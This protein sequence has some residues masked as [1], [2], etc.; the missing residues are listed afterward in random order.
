MKKVFIAGFLSALVA[1]FA[2]CATNANTSATGSNAN[3]TN[4]NA[5]PAPIA[6]QPKVDSPPL[7]AEVP[8]FTDARE[9]LE[10]G[11]RYFENNQDDKAINAFE[12]AVKLDPDSG[13]AHFHLGVAYQLNESNQT[14]EETPAPSPSKSSKSKKAPAKLPE[15]PS[16]KE[17]RA[18]IKAYEAYLKKNPKDATAN[19]Y[20]GL[21]YQKIF[22]DEKARKVL[23]EAVKL[24]PEDADYQYELGVVLIKLAQYD[25]AVSALK[26]SLQIDP[27]NS[28][29]ESSLEKAQAGKKRIDA[30]KKEL[31]DSKPEEPP[32]PPRSSRTKPAAAPPGVKTE[33]TPEPPKE[34]APVNKNSNNL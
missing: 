5:A 32:P 20:L 14:E 26:K 8:V 22:E 19:Y 6:E 2:G 9:A 18:A 1:V 23:Q 15:K 17:F 33:K 25:E 4:S 13:E 27:D 28:R 16:E 31:A 30:A 24:A 7:P 12:Q 10:L 21:S 29:A 3:A 34:T 11:K